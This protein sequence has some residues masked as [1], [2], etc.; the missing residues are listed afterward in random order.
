MLGS[1][2]QMKIHIVDP[3]AQSALLVAPAAWR[4]TTR[5]L[6]ERVGLSGAQQKGVH[7]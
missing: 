6:M 4:F 5:P 2:T 7:A 1:S 3:D